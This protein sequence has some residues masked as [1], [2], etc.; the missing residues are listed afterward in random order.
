MLIHKRDTRTYCIF[1]NY[2]VRVEQQDV[3]TL[4]DGYALII[5]FCKT[6]VF[7]I[8]NEYY[9]REVLR[10]QL[11]RPVYRCII[12]HNDFT[13]DMLKGLDDRSETVVQEGVD[14]ITDDDDRDFQIMIDYTFSDNPIFVLAIMDLPRVSPSAY[15]SSPPNATPRAIILI[16]TGCDLS[17]LVR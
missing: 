6:G 1:R 4:C 15:S 8:C 2:G 9:F 13:V 12:D 14:I 7:C 5:C 17:N 16:V 10:Y 3:F 11:G